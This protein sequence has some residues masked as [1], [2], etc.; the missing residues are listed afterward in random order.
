LKWM[1]QSPAE[2]AQ[3]PWYQFFSPRGWARIAALAGLA[4]VFGARPE[5][6][7]ASVW[8]AM[9]GINVNMA[10]LAILG[11][12]MMLSFSRL[13]WKISLRSA[14][15]VLLLTVASVT[16]TLCL[17]V[18]GGLVPH[19]GLA[20]LL[21]V[22]VLVGGVIAFGWLADPNLISLHGFYKARLSRKRLWVP[23]RARMSRSRA[24]CAFSNLLMHG[25]HA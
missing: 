2:A 17:L 15:P 6:S 21:W 14:R 24:G 12:V 3:R 23:Y 16:A 18:S 25:P 11:A 13:G 4:A 19:L 22:V 1:G 8:K 10:A 20:A 5:S 9:A 7:P